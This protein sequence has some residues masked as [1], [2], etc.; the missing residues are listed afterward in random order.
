M[1]S[2]HDARLKYQEG[3]SI[4]SEKLVLV[5]ELQRKMR[6]AL[7]A[8]QW[9][10][11]QSYDAQIVDLVPKLA[12]DIP[13][14]QMEDELIKLRELYGELVSRAQQERSDVAGALKQFHQE[15]SAASQYLNFSKL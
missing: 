11:I 9:A 15:K 2:V 5:H 8:E 12:E 1:A 4:M 10:E 6:D 7:D 14:A 3:V 13:R